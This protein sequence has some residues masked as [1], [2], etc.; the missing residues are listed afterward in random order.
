MER[1]RKRWLSQNSSNYL[2]HCLHGLRKTMEDS[3]KVAGNIANI[4]TEYLLNKV[5]N[6]TLNLFLASVL[7]IRVKSFLC[8]NW[9]PHHEG[10]LGEW[11]CNSMQFDLGTRWRWVVSFTP[12]PLYSQENSPWYPL[13]RGLCSAQDF[14]WEPPH[15]T[16]AVSL[17][18]LTCSVTQVYNCQ[19]P[20]RCGSSQVI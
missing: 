7:P 20:P 16:S 11:G 6:L 14:N 8:F 18:E 4:Q 9:A 5:R 10:I 2:G 17:L 1:T 13:D 15:Y 19:L 12:W 3:I